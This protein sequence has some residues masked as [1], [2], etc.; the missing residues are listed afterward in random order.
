MSNKQRVTS[1]E[2]RVKKLIALYSLLIA[3]YSLLIAHH[4]LL[5]TTILTNFF[6]TT[7]SFLISFPAIHSFIFSSDSTAFLIP[8]SSISAPAI[9]LPLTLPF[10]WT[11]IVISSDFINLGS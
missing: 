11:T 7:T 1:K 8:S 9:I 2:Q 4:S 10:I 3:L 6:G 5:Y